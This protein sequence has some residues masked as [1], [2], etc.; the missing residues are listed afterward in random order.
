MGFKNTDLG[1]KN[2]DLGLTNP[3]SILKFYPKPRVSLNLG[4]ILFMIPSRQ[5]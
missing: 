2:V 5:A 4:F 3:G 1:F